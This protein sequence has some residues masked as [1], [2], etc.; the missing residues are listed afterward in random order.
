MV[1]SQMKRPGLLVSVRSAEEAEAALAGGA[2]IID[3]KEPAN[4]PL[5][6][7]EDQTIDAILSRV[8]GRRPI[9]AALGELAEELPGFVDRRLA[10]VK[11]GLAGLGGGRQSWEARLSLALFE[12]GP[13]QA[14]V[15]AYAD[16]Q[17]A[18]APRIEDVVA[19]A[20]SSGGGTLL[21]D[22]HCK[23]ATAGGRRPTLLDWLAPVDLSALCRQCRAAGVRVAVAG[24]LTGDLVKHLVASLET[25]P[26]WFAVRGAAC[27]EGDRRAAIDADKVRGFVQ[28]LGHAC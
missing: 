22:T 12:A 26:D 16:W 8:A 21:I 20:C 15:A 3:I 24:S 13:P 14:V 2:H 11:W 19:F 4:G 28:L 23:E 6:R 9:S 7:A 10:Y 27:A 1:G 17:S 25:V 5:G 18:R